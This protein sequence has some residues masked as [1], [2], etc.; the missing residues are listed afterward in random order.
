MSRKA[1]D[2][3]LYLVTDR[4]ICGIKTID[5]VVDES[6]GGGVTLVQLREK[7][8]THELFLERAKVLKNAIRDRVPLV[9]ND[10]IEIAFEVGADGVHVGQS[11]AGW[12]VARARLGQH[13]IIGVSVETLD[14][15]LALE[16]ADIDYVGVS[17]VFSTAT[18]PDAGAPWGLHGLAK[19]R[20]LTRHPCVAIGGISA[21]NAR[22][23]MQAGAAGVAV[24]SAICAAESPKRAALELRAAI[25]QMQ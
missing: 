1:L 25:D 17:P 22:E 18:K 10:D 6:I 13:A 12:Q 2:L 24:V 16:D 23:V 7:H 19:L 9:I 4:A 14:Q 8:V 15:A 20:G 5:E 3:R 11:D 21:S